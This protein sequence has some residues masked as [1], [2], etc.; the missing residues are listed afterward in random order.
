MPYILLLLT[1]FI[2]A[3]ILIPLLIKIGVKHNLYDKPGGDSL[4][5]HEKPIPFLGGI[6]M[7]LALAISIG[8]IASSWHLPLH[9]SKLIV[10]I[11]SAL[12]FLLLGFLDDVIQERTKISQPKLKF[13]A[14]V[15]L[16]V[17]ITF[18]FMLTDIKAKFIPIILFEILIV[19]FYILCAINAV[20]LEDGLDSLAGG[21]VAISLIGFIILSLAAYNTL[22]L[23]LSI[24]LLGALIGFLI[25]NWHP[26]SIFMGDGGSYFLGFFLA[27]F[28]I[29]FTNRPHDLRAFLGPILII[30]IPFFDTAFVA[31]TR[32]LR[33]QSIFFGDRNHLYD[34]IYKRSNSV[35]KTIFIY[36]SIQG[37]IV[38]LGVFVYLI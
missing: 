6:G 15:I 24:S 12:F 23:V 35:V 21:L 28:A 2:S 32:I 34:K 7:F 11:S 31:V 25:Y 9:K 18:L 37:L 19:F 29:N 26:A 3:L 14:Q 1:S 8:V 38:S 17:L 20:N 10:I 13:Y 30:G 16:A 36:Y 22:F 4:K 33:K 27:V 5:I